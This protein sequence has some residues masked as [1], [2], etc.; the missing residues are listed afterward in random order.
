MCERERERERE[1]DR[2]TDRQ[3]A[4]QGGLCTTYKRFQE[5]ASG[6]EA[7]V[8]STKTQER[9]EADALFHY[10][11]GVA[12]METKHNH[13]PQSAHRLLRSTELTP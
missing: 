7:I 3:T 6:S 9:Q 13:M 11:M 8:D 10:L 12:H 5:V 4:V 2:Q 1:T